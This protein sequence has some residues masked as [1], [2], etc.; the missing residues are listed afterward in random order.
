MIEELTTEQ[1]QILRLNG[2]H[3]QENGHWYKCRVCHNVCFA[4]GDVWI[5]P[6]YA[7]YHTSCVLKSAQVK[8]L[9]R[10]K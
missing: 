10:L 8:K 2:W 3:H 5:S 6:N 9:L 7:F 1:K 4:Y